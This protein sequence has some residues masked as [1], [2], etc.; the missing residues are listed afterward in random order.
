MVAFVDLLE[1]RGLLE[2]R[3][4][5]DDRRTRALHLTD[6]GR[7]LL[8]R[9]FAL[10]VADERNLCADLTDAERT[11]VLEL[12]GPR[13]PPPR[14]PPGGRTPPMPTPRCPTPD[15]RVPGQRAGGAV[16]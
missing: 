7:D 4:N 15:P 8:E 9:A 13:R 6:A 2:R 12:L 1:S 5:A 16:G 11:Q 14:H 3:Q 10:A